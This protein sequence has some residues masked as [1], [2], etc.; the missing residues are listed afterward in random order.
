MYRILVLLAFVLAAF[1]AR[2]E[3]AILVLDESGSMWAQLEGKTRIEIARAVIGDMLA[4]VP[5]ERALGLVAYGHRRE[6]DCSDIE[7]I[8]PVGTDRATI[9][10]RVNAMKP[11]GKTP[12]TDGVRFA[13]QKLN[14]TEGKATVI[15]VSDGAESCNKDPCALGR[16]L[17]AAGA[18]FTVHVVGF[19]LESE[20]ESAG[21]R[22]LAEA[23]GG[24]Y[25]AARDAQQ[26][27]AALI[28]TVAAPLPAPPVAAPTTGHIVLRATELDGGPE[29]ASGLA[30]RVA[31]AGSEPV[32]SADN[33]GV[34][35]ATIAPGKYV[36]QVQRADGSKGSAAFELQAGAERTVTIPLELV[37]QA[38]L[39]L[40]P[41]NTAP[42]GSKVSVQ[43]TGPDRDGDFVTVVAKGDVPTAYNSY[44]Y[45]KAGNPASLSLPAFAGDYEVRY[46]LG[47]PSRVLAAVPYTVTPANATVEAP[48]K[49]SAGAAFPITWTGPN[50]HGDWLT[51][52]AP[53]AAASEYASY[54]DAGNPS[55]A[56]LNAPLAPG[57]YELRYV[58][59]GVNVLVRK[60]ISVKAV[61]ASITG[62]AS[63]A[64]GSAFQIEWQG[65]NNRSDWLTIIAPAAAPS[66]YASY[67]DAIN[68]SP[69][70]L[71]APLEP[72]AYE[73]RYVAGG[74]EVLARTP[75]MVTAVTASIEA[76]ESV[77]AGAQFEISW[78]GPNNHGD[79]LT[80]VKPDAAAQMYGSYA[81]APNGSPASLTAPTVAGDYQLRYVQDGKLVLV[82]RGI[83]V[84]ER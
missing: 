47:R 65:P 11:K 23:T 6:G 19:A 70:R 28:A 46:V 36:A 44:A 67:V 72:G 79:W 42:A 66:V 30:W 14:Y 39:T 10:A 26:L 49:V 73:L 58:A 27:S 74:R 12:L 7:E 22:C 77:V 75:I 54:V 18:D 52:I 29:I 53:D 78:Q 9:L 55:P 69:A 21:L 83:R 24:R 71:N 62:P 37:L 35:E 84:T 25:F 41:A 17:E 3:N 50:A 63:V 38:T 1:T 8:V 15:L 2:A 5:A 31:A 40:I 16:E 4:Q 51:I 43:W 57:N 81:D 20:T 61:A 80:I 82:R 64:A 32:F 68:G 48:A 13:A 76:P 60:P 34:A 59:A 45:T 33:A 56:T